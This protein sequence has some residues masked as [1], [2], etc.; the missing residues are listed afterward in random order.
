MTDDR[1]G[2]I[3]RTGDGFDVVFDR[4]IAKPIDKVWAA[5][6]TPERIADWFA[7]VDLDLRLGG[8]YRLKFSPEETPVDGVIVA[9]EPPRLLA[10]TWPDP[11]HPDSI[12]RYELE[13]DGDGCRLRFSQTGLPA[14]YVA[15]IAGWHLFLDAIPGAA[16]SVRFVWTQ[17]AEKVVLELYRERLAAV[18][19]TL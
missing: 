13:P 9:F 15:A 17:A 19:V 14:K 5:I 11:E 3:T 16:E 4:R 8:H 12:V 18:G 2:T 10:H 6:T 7:I 1:L